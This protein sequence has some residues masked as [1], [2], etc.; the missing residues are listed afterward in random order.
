MHIDRLIK[1]A[2]N[3]S[4]EETFSISSKW[5]QGRT[6][7][8]GLSAALLFAVTQAKVS[9][10]RVVRSF[11]CNFI[12]PLFVDEECKLKVD[13]LREGKNVS[14]LQSSIIQGNNIC[15]QAQIVFGAARQSKLSVNN[16]ESHG[17]SLPK[18]PSF[19]PNIPKM[20]PK[21]LKHFEMAIVE[22][23][24]FTGSKDTTVSGWMRFKKASEQITNAHLIALIDAWP[25]TLLQQ[26]RLPAPASTM[27]WTVNFIRPISV[28][29]ENTWFA[30][31][32]KTKCF[33]D[34]YGISDAN[35]WDVQGHLIATSNQIFTIFA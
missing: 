3:L 11:S 33:S 6:V 12:G 7:F 29:S 28:D 5:S 30:Y 20:T 1:Q 31:K 35:I 15:V 14:V 23:K 25:P 16:T 34:G 8:G 4:D 24:P 27:T 22:G 26:L 21:A 17:M 9:S 19:L 32:A 2:I 10:E 13:V 18:K